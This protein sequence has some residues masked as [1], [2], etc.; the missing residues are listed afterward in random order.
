[1]LCLRIC[2]AS[3]AASIQLTDCY[4]TSCMRTLRLYKCIWHY[5]NLIARAQ[6]IKSTRSPSNR[7]GVRDTDWQ[8]GA[9][10]T[11]ALWFNCQLRMDTAIL[12]CC[13]IIYTAERILRRKIM[14]RTDRLVDWKGKWNWRRCSRHHSNHHYYVLY[15]SLPYRYIWHHR[16]AQHEHKRSAIS[17]WCLNFRAR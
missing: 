17:A 16:F 13:A 7:D 9:L 6:L 2:T 11:S 10:F 5:G 1:M 14:R 4:S 15:A 8:A 12:L 3:T